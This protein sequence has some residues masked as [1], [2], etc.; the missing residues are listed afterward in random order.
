M[1]T[2]YR[3][4]WSTAQGA[5]VVAS[6]LA[7]VRRGNRR[8]GSGTNTLRVAALTLALSLAG[9][10]PVLAQSVTLGVYDPQINDNKVGQQIV[11]AGN[12]M[13]ISGPQQFL[14]GDSGARSTTLGA[15]NTAGKIVSGSQWIGA[16]RL[17]PGTINFGVTVPDPITGGTRV[18]STYATAN[19]VPLTP[20]DMNTSVP[21][22][23]NVNGAQYIDA[24]VGTVTSAGGTLNVNVGTAGAASTAST[25]GWTM[26]AKQSSLFYADGSAGVASNINWQSNN[27]ITFIGDVA[28]PN[29]PQNYQVTYVSSYGGTFTV[30]TLDGV[31]NT[32]AVNNDSDLRTYND[33]LISQIRAGNLDPAQYTNEFNKAYASS[34]Q[35]V[36]YNISANNPADEIAQPIGLRVVMHTIGNNGRATVN[37]GAKLEVVNSNG[38]AMRAESGGTLT[39]NGTLAT[40]HT[41]GDGT[42]MFMTGSSSGTNNGVINGNFFLNTN[43]STVDGAYGSNVVD[44]AAASAFTNNGIINLATGATNGAGASAGIRLNGNSNANNTGI[45]NV[46]V[47]GSKSNGSMTGVLLADGTGQFTNTSTGTIYIGRGPQTSAGTTPADVAVNQGTLTAGITVNGNATANNQGTITIGSRTQNAAGIVVSNAPN[48]TV[49]NTG[50][51]NING[52]A[53]TVPRENDGILVTNSGAGGGIS[54]AGTINLNGVNGVGI[55]VLS[56]NASASTVSSSGTINVAGGADPGSGTRNFGVWVEGQAS[57]TAT[58][59]VSGPVNLLGDG[60]IGIHA[61]GRATVDVLAGAEPTFANGTRQIAFFAYGTNAKINVASDTLNVTTTGSTLFRMENGAGFDGTGLNLTASGA[62]SVAVL[63]TGA[64]SVVNTKNAQIQVTG[65]GATGV[66]IEGGAV[67][68]IDAATTMHLSGVGAVAGIVD[69]QKHSLTGANTGSPVSTTSLTTAATLTESQTA[70]TGY[71]ARNSAKLTNTGHI[72]F[73]GAHSTGIRVE[74]GATATNSGNITV[75]DGGTGILVDGSIGNSTTTANTTGIVTANGGSVADR[76]RG[77]IAT[78]SKAVMNLQNGSQV[79]LNGVGA[80]GAEAVN[81]GTVNVAASALPVFANTDQIAF[82]A[83]GAGAQIISAASAVDASTANSTIYRIDDGATL[84]LSGTPVLTSSGAG[85]RG[86]TGSGT[87]TQVTTGATTFNVSGAGASG[88]EVDG[89]ATGT[90]SAASTVNLSGIGSI[91]GIVDGQKTDISGVAVGSPVATTLTNNG[92]V[93]GTGANAV[94]FIARNQGSLVNAGAV[95]MTGSGNTGVWL[96]S[97]GTLTN[98]NSIHVANGT[99]VRVEG[100]QSKIAGLGT[101]TVDNGVAGIQLLNGAQTSIDGQGGS[102]VTHGTAH[103]ILLDTGASSLTATHATITTDGTGNGIENAAEIG[104]VSLNNLTINTGNGAGIRTATAFDPASTVTMNV[105][106]SG[107]GF[108]FRNADGSTA[109]SALNLSQNYVVNANGAGA[110]GIQALTSGAVTTAATV[111]VT[112]AA[113]GSA[114]VAGTASTT[115]NTGK[116]VSAST[117]SPVVDLSNGTGTSFTNTGTIQAS[118]ATGQA[119]RGSAGSDTISLTG[120]SVQGDI[121][122]GNGSDNFSWTAG[123]LN[124][125]LSMGSGPNNQ[126]LV[127]G[128]DLSSTYHLTS[129]VGSGNTLNL[130]TITYRGGSFAADDLSKGVNLGSGWNTI[131]FTKTAF[132]L[133]DNLRLAHS[134][135]TIDSASTLFAGDNVHPVISDPTPGGVRVTNA[136]TIDLTNGAGSPGN[137]LT[138][139]GDYISQAGKINLIT[140]LNLGS[141]LSNQFTDRLL[142]QG[143]VTVPGGATV[144]NITPS[145]ASTGALTDFNHNSAVDANEGISVVQVAGSS[146]PDAFRL[147]GG[148]LAAGP[149][150]YGLYAFEPG[151]SSATQRVV[152]GSGN[153]FWD[154]RLANIYVCETDCVPPTKANPPPT[155]PPGDPAPAPLPP[156]TVTPPPAVTEAPNDG[157]VVNGIDKCAPGRPAVTPQVPSYISA[158]GALAAY[159]FRVLDN[160]HKRL[161]EIRHETELDDGQGGEAFARYIGGDYTYKT[162]LRFNE[163]GYDYDQHVSALQVGANIFNIDSEKSAMRAGVAFTHGRTRVEPKAADGDSRTKFYSNSIAMYLTWQHVNGFYVDGVVSGERHQGDVS[164]ARMQ[165]VG[166]LRAAGW[167]AS[168]ETGYPWRFDNGYTLEPQLQL[169]RLHER[170]DT[171]VDRDGTR[172][173]YNDYDQTIG[174]LGVRLTRTWDRGNGQ[175]GTPY[176]RLNY[177]KGWG[178]RARVNVGDDT[179]SSIDQTFI[180]GAYGQAVELGLGG[181]YSLRKQ[182]SFYGE[183]DYQKEIGSGGTRGWSFNVGARWD[184]Q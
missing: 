19:L 159:G 158:P 145:A 167:T 4:V 171:L 45:I 74:S 180:G 130:D 46:G 95:N 48:A 44:L 179:A 131:N 68:T 136:G 170:I 153:Q 90:L 36:G 59:N 142:V 149:W 135:V 176:V 1:N 17:N 116:L 138:I 120:G 147:V 154:Y 101:V 73:S 69:G 37:S 132:T 42:A 30:T 65:S 88:L 58:A 9:I 38:G 87:G 85:A 6:E 78:G 166:H 40:T 183:A 164:I 177:I 163:F 15:L 94:G 134:D 97:G 72:T 123:T 119:I 83:L 140:T 75:Q 129:G 133:T 99:G 24:R 121:A 16:G 64:P 23:V 128:V 80:I 43:G 51:I 157:C 91:G 111:N 174:R 71:I 118:S 160:L 10:G 11:G 100:A 57:G 39:N 161:G 3:L 126:A 86:I 14:A 110:T 115:T 32:K 108:A 103:G 114:L 63:G 92:A 89:G 152:A 52:K 41:S 54:N 112:N 148:Y 151:S 93:N 172:V 124:G 5:W 146:T 49:N 35:N 60:A 25:N 56:T 178:G 76:T 8:G 144:L 34:T 61:R 7:Q 81:G 168:V 169:A 2:I 143:N 165:D 53:A 31:A 127:K 137:S 12:T 18:V 27:R 28:A 77:V 62:N 122:T 66:V 162:N 98:S 184:F 113:G 106:G 21:D 150:Q 139:D 102:V 47:T 29:Q 33:W 125:S 13:T 141:A 96:Q 67:G 105:A 70:L 50:T 82:H 181:T 156:A 55:K 107:T 26:A 117:V 104:T 84:A 22:E 155:P 182:L 79:Q 109:S 175:F 173:N 20:V